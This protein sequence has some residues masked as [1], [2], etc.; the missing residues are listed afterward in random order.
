MPHQ[1]Y[2][3]I[4][5]A[6]ADIRGAAVDGLEVSVSTLN[7]SLAEGLVNG[8]V[9]PATTIAISGGATNFAAFLI[10]EDGAGA[11]TLTE[12]DDAGVSAAAALVVALT[13]A[14]P[15]GEVGIVAGSNDATDADNPFSVAVRGKLS[16]VTDATEL[17]P[18]A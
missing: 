1:G 5:T 13:I 14:V 8:R 9:L 3:N 6:E 4:N 16:P 11:Y 12:V 2:A 17:T 18:A 10:S 15:A 7:V